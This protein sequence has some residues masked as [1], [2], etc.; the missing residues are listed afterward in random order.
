MWETI[1]EKSITASKFELKKKKTIVQEEGKRRGKRGKQVW[2]GQQ[3]KMF[4]LLLYMWS[5]AAQHEDMLLEV[6]YNIYVI[7]VINPLSFIPSLSYRFFK[8]HK[9]QL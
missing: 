9:I 8:T 2:W 6:A 1:S 7:N 5:R 3:K 4:N